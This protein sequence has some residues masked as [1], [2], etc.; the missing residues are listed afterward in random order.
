MKKTTGSVVKSI[1]F[2]L[3]TSFS[4]FG[5]TGWISSP[6]VATAQAKAAVLVGA[7]D[8]A[9]CSYNRDESTAKLLDSIGGTV[10]TL[11]DNVYPSGT[12][13]EYKNC[14]GPTWG[15]HKQRTRPSP[16]NHE[17]RTDGA[18]GYYS[19]F[20][21][22]ASPRQPNCTS[23]CN[24][25]YSYNLGAWHIIVLN[26]E[27]PMSAG[28]AQEKWLRADLKAHPKTCTLAYWHKPRFSSGDHGNFTKAQP[29]W[30]ALYDYRADVVLNGH[31]HIYERF[32]PQNPS[33][34]ADP[35]RGIRQFVVGTGGADLYSFSR[36]KDNSQV[37]NNTSWGVLKLVLYPTSY[38]WKFIPIAGSTFT[39]S[40]TANCV[41]RS[42]ASTNLIFRDNF[43]PASLLAWSFE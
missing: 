40:G 11:G 28:S 2:V 42:T 20:G 30:Q 1:C 34:K 27:I 10:F 19:Y 6:E 24:G 4:I 18:A 5:S 39:D 33:G 23:N 12:K 35:N 41:R 26:S 32:A 22:A 14:Y 25:Y 17:Y 21:A 13:T 31:D 8:I 38:K 37:R 43:E 3:V 16:G 15:R 29:L 9:S 7:G 36:I